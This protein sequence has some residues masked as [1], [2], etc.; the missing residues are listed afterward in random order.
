MSA[1]GTFPSRSHEEG[2]DLHT[3]RLSG[4][5]K[6]PGRRLSPAKL[7]R[8]S[9]HQAERQ[10]SISEN[11]PRSRSAATAEPI[12]DF[13]GA[14]EAA[15]HAATVS[16]VQGL[17]EGRMRLNP[18]PVGNHPGARLED[19]RGC[20]MWRRPWYNFSYLT[21]GLI[22]VPLSSIRVFSRGCGSAGVCCDAKGFKEV[23]RTVWA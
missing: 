9:R 1:G 4:R 10:G 3:S 23:A 5:R 7:T 16:N 15:C 18:P 6:C 2:Q 17:Q 19:L 21:S 14:G 11:E 13:D 20:P 12:S 22:K 8:R